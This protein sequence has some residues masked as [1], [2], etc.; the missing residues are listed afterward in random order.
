MLIIW[1][2]Q[3]GTERKFMAEHLFQA[4]FW[5]PFLARYVLVW[6]QLKSLDAECNTGKGTGL[7]EDFAL[8]FFGD[9]LLEVR[10]DFIAAR[11]HS[12][13][14]FFGQIRLAFFRQLVR[15]ERFQL[16]K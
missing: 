14:F 9:Q 5:Y 12:L 11:H 4:R 8:T 13:D 15:T 7:V 10:D 6:H 16:L 1:L 3:A 2:L